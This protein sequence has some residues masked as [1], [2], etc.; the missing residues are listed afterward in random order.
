MKKR[1]LDTIVE[2]VYYIQNRGK[3]HAGWDQWCI[4]SPHY[5]TCGEA[6]KRFNSTRQWPNEERRLVRGVFISKRVPGT[7]SIYYLADSKQR[8]LAKKSR[9]A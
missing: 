2:V 5:Q 6:R 3:Y 8:I 7:R 9:P 1:I 4:C